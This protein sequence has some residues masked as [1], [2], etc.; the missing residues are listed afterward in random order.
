MVP[1]KQKS[2]VD[3]SQGHTGSRC[4]VCRYYQHTTRTCDLVEG[5]I[6]PDM[7]CKLFEP[8]TAAMKRAA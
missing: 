4:G 6:H 8:N 3:Y 7:W 5:D 2:E 1:K